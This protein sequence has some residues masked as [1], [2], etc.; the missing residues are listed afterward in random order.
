M[1]VWPVHLI[2][3][4]PNHHIALCVSDL[5][6]EK[7]AEPGPDEALV[8]LVQGTQHKTRGTRSTAGERSPPT[9][10]LHNKPSNVALC[11]AISLKKT[12]D[13]GWHC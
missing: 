2:R 5:V 1:L 9:T 13:V 3:M 7:R 8:K 11:C 6:G 10:V 4:L 12:A